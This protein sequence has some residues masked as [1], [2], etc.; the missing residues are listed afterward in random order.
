M[1]L[2]FIVHP[3]EKRFMLS[4]LLV[5]VLAIY[6][7]TQSRY[8]A[9][10]EKAM[11]SGAIQLEDPISFEATWQVL[12]EYPVWKKISYSTVNWIMTN[13]KGM[14]FGVLFGAAFLTLFGY[15]RQRSFRG[16]FANS[17]FGLALG[18]PLGVCVNCA[19][20]IARGL[21][22]G[23]ARAE[24]TLSAMIASPTLNIVVLTMLFSIMP[25]YMAV[26]KVGLSLLMVLIAVPIICRFLPKEQLQVENA[27][28]CTVPLGRSGIMP[29]SETVFEAV[30]QFV[31][32]YAANLWFIVRV[33]VP[34]MLLAGFLGAVVATLVP[35]EMLETSRFGILTVAGASLIGT[36]LPVPIAFDVVVS[37]AL[38]SGGL[39]HGLTM[40]LLFTLGIFSIY[41][42]FI[43]ATGI[44]MR[45]GTILGAV[46]I[47]VGILAGLGA[48][49]Y[50]KWQTQRALDILTGFDLSFVN[51]AHA[52]EAEFYREF[53]Q[54]NEI[55]AIS[56]RPH[57]ERSTASETPFTRTE[58]W[59]LGIDKPLEFS[60]RDMWPPFWEGRSI[61]AGDYDNDGDP[62]V[63]FASTE[64]G[65]YFYKNDGTGNFTA[66]EIPIGKLKDE[67]VFNAA[68]VDVDNDS[69]LDLF[70]TTY[71]SGNFIMRNRNGSFDASDLQ[72]VINQE[73][74]MLSLA[75]T[76]GDV[77]RDGDLDLALGN[78]AAG[79]YRRIPG[80]ESRNRIVF[81]EDGKL[82]GEKF[83]ELPG[84]P[85]ETL[86][87]VFSDINGDGATDLLEGNDFEMP[88][89]FYMGDGKG[90]FTPITRA[91]GV[92]PMTT[93]T[94]MAIKTADLHND[95]VPEIYVAQIAG[96]SSGVSKK[97][98]MRSLEYYC[99]AVEREADRAACEKNM[100][101]KSWYK[102]G[103]NFDPTYASKC[104]GLEG[105]YQAEC[106]G[107]L[108]KDLAIQNRDPA[109]CGLVPKDQ[110][111]TRALCDIHFRK[112]QAPTEAQIDETV[113]QILR[114]NVLLVRGDG[115][116]YAEKAEEQGL[117]VGGWSWDTKI[118]DLDNDGFQDVYIVNGTWVPNEVSPSNLF[119][120]NNGH[121]GFTEETGP[122]GL[123]D[124]LIT[125]AAA[126]FDF[127]NDGDLD[128]ITVP[129]NGPTMA[130]INN[131]SSGNSIAFELRDSVGNH[132]GIGARVEIRYGGDGRMQTRELQLGGGFMSFDAPVASFGLGDENQIDSVTIAWAD[133]TESVID[134]AL[135][136]GS[137]YR[138]ARQMLAAN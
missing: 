92:I 127:D 3:Y 53:A 5:A 86:S 85:G 50:Q 122:F 130:F 134:E 116:E 104:Q 34:L 89:Y 110:P 124:Y 100:A 137:V 125:A 101:I 32:N 47:V 12:P 30:W 54:G 68:L 15:L 66:D 111:R 94:T 38:L 114:R 61:A 35:V 60:F 43:V 96:R 17:A 26:A 91:E 107:M 45:A 103:N 42:Y 14:T 29:E 105:K 71:Q 9:L 4:V 28:A 52:D 16:G 2:S 19:A 56:R 84:L 128:I 119:F 22:T 133:G 76:F 108:V 69:W 40:T 7:W 51:S 73:D 65:L 20:P 95:G 98:K 21:Y 138:I 57:T 41:S 36:F 44:S 55:I 49:S 58:A 63:V 64:R 70:I 131:S 25:F 90:G 80:E 10:D 81:N 78:W 126:V 46:V 120:R 106:K 67:P 132:Y 136:A 118:A 6:F 79:W 59:H 62:D 135:E 18:A 13:R 48:N 99:D 11:M 102:S 77:D 8:P 23:G 1:R 27:D 123:E 74:A 113:P 109:I 87:M 33:T 117:D 83:A 75:A 88:D 31:R 112:F 115:G 82:T 93:T 72:P 24:A 121:G 39:D 129:V 37:G 97:L